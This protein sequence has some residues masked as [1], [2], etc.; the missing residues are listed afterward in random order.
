MTS[1]GLLLPRLITLSEDVDDAQAVCNLASQV[2][3][4]AYGAEF[5]VTMIGQGRIYSTAVEIDAWDP[6][7]VPLP[8]GVANTM[9]GRGAKLEAAA[10]AVRS[11]LRALL[12]RAASEGLLGDDEALGL[13][14]AADVMIADHLVP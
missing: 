1:G 2:S 6:S 11:E 9:W 12:E 13:R 7:A 10:S 4:Q 5:R 3:A 8:R 14:R